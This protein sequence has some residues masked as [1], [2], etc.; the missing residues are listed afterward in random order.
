MYRITDVAKIPI[1]GRGVNGFVARE[2][3]GR[4]GE[5]GIGY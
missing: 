2:G 4:S 3:S 5:W 1:T